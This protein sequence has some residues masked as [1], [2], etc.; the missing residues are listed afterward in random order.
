MKVSKRIV[1]VSLVVAALFLSATAVNAAEKVLKD[2][3]K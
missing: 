1:K 3:V 2:L